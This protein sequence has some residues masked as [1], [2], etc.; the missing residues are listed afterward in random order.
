MQ[1][2]LKQL[3]DENVKNKSERRELPEKVDN[4]LL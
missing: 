1:E 3:R 2:A 4:V